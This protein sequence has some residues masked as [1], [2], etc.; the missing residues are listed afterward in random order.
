MRKTIH[1]KDGE[2]VRTGGSFHTESTRTFADG[3]EHDV[4]YWQNAFELSEGVIGGLV[5]AIVD[6]SDQKKLERDLAAAK[7]AAESAEAAT[8]L[9]QRVATAANEAS[10]AEA[11]IQVCLDEVCAYTSWPAG[12]AYVLADDGTGELAP[13]KIWHLDHGERFDSFRRVT[14]ETRFAP[15]VGLPGRVLASGEPAWIIDVTKDPNFPRAQSATD[16]GVKAGFAFPVS[17]AGEVL[18]VLEFFSAEAMEPAP[19]FLDIIAEVGAQLGR[20]IQRLRAERELA[21]SQERSQALADNMQVALSS[22]SDGIFILDGDL[23]YVAFNQRYVDLLNFPE[24]MV[25]E[26]GPIVDLVEFAA[27]RGDYGS[28]FEGDVDDVVAGRLKQ[29]KSEKEYLFENITP[30]GRIVEY[31]GSPIKGGGFVTIMH[32]ITERRQAEDALRESEARLKGFLDYA[33]AMVVIKDTELRYILVNKAFVEERGLP[34]EEIIGKTTQDVLPA[35][36]AEKIGEMD[37]EVLETGKPLEFESH[38]LNANGERRET[39]V[40]KYPVFAE[41]G[42]I[43]AI[44]SFS[45]DITERK[46]AETALRESEAQLRVVLDNMPGGMMLGD[47]NRNYVLFN[48]Q[49]SELHDY[50][51][52]LLKVGGSLLDETR[53]QADRGDY[54]PGDKDD[55]IDRVVATYQRDE[56]VS[57]E[58]TIPSG[59]TL[60]FNVGPTP[61][62]GYVTIA[63]DITERK[64]AEAAIEEAYGIIKV[65]RDRMEE[66][67]NVGREIRMSMI[68]LS[69]PP[70][71][72]RGEF[73]IDAVLEPAREVGG[74]FYDFYFVDE[75]RLCVCIGDVS[76]KGVPSALFMAVAKTLIKSRAVDDPSTA[77][78]MT[79]VNGELSRDNPSCMFVTIFIGILDVGTGELMFTNAGHNPPYVKGGDGALRRL[80]QRHG[81]VIGAVEDL[82]YAEERIVLAPGDVLYMYTDGV[83]EAMDGEGA[84]YSDERLADWLASTTFSSTEAMVRDTVAE[85]EEFEGEAEQ[86]DDITVM[87]LRFLGTPE[88]APRASFS[89]VAANELAEIA[90]VRAGFEAFVEEAGVPAAVAVRFVLALDELLN[91]II[92]HAY[93]DDD[94]HAIE[95]KAELTGRRLALTVADD[96]IPFNPLLA[97]DPDTDASIEDRD[98][99]GLGI[100]LVLGVVDDFT[101]QRRIDKNVVTLIKELD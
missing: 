57:Y 52:G 82:V 71:P 93:R 81:P 98:I 9:L 74:D 26:G 24:G 58:R 14:E 21:E 40:I 22:M 63:T 6:I 4:L 76:G 44:G 46:Q 84:L 51:D 61:E 2:L 20:V 29:M 68:P 36:Q 49:Y 35:D 37:R 60:N 97:E 16:I 56:A 8:R 12:H 80:D 62:G 38:M 91:N 17:I 101:Y 99:G 18:G 11:A 23:N 90:K 43:V 30:T 75:D 41:D 47:E 83:T 72:D 5:G 45:N 78:I 92:S 19:G 31:R 32:D 66:E 33:N 69:F 25:R 48:S 89:V 64:R 94:A 95:V 77:S 87:A 85:V 100:H 54:G 79:H 59:R 73:S 39:F 34:A 50:P 88:D 13:M 27:R 67:L 10:A 1:E 3:E 28:Q 42:S 7:E 86:A 53:F 55:L 65:Q 15:G 70:F 96:G